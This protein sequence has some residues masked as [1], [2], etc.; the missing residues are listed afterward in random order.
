MFAGVDV[1]GE[2]FFKPVE[3]IRSDEVHFAGEAGAVAELAQIV[4]ERGNRGRELRSVVIRADL[5][6]ELASHERKPC[7]SHSGEL[8]YAA[9]KRMP[10]AA[11]ASRFGVC[12]IGWPEV[13]V[14]CGASWS[15]MITTMFGRLVTC[16]TLLPS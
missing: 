8:Q 16:R 5:G 14:N 2:A 13:P 9:S 4:G 11:S 3:L 7:G 10:R 6:D 1:G 15:A 12:T